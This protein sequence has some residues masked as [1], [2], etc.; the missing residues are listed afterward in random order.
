MK[1]FNLV[2]QFNGDRILAT[3]EA[4][5]RILKCCRNCG[6][7]GGHWGHNRCPNPMRCKFCGSTT[8]DSGKNWECP[9]WCRYAI[10]TFLFDDYYKKNLKTRN[11]FVSLPSNMNDNWIMNDWVF[12]PTIEELQ[13][14]KTFEHIKKIWRMTDIIKYNIQNNDIFG[15]DLNIEDLSNILCEEKSDENNLNSNLNQEIARNKLYYNNYNYNNN[16]QLDKYK[17]M[18]KQRMRKNKNKNK[19][20]NINNIESNMNIDNKTDSSEEDDNDIDDGGGGWSVSRNKGNRLSTQ[21]HRK[22]LRDYNRFEMSS[23]KNNNNNLSKNNSVINNGNNGKNG[24]HGINSK[25]KNKNGKSVDYVKI[26]EKLTN[27]NSQNKKIKNRRNRKRKRVEDERQKRQK[28]LNDDF[29]RAKKILNE[30]REKQRDGE[31]KNNYN[32]NNRHT[33]QKQKQQQQQTPIIVN[34]SPDPPVRTQ[35]Q[36]QQ[37]PKLPTVE[38]LGNINSMVNNLQANQYQH[39]NSINENREYDNN[40]YLKEN[41]SMGNMNGRNGGNNRH[42][43]PKRDHNQRTLDLGHPNSFVG[44]HQADM[45][46]AAGDI[47]NGH[48][49]PT[50]SYM[51]GDQRFTNHN[52]NNNTYSLNEARFNP[53]GNTNYYN[54][55]NNNNN[56]N[57]NN[58][59]GRLGRF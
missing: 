58:G 31:F 12:T 42:Y 52:Y 19:N 45:V 50:K 14:G 46:N 40:M 3:R 48:Y 39:I 30:N 22:L 9:Y 1:L 43:R 11:G 44:G 27:I 38:N 20:K 8:H 41:P 53:I 16:I 55:K 59:Y 36:Q 49:G 6:H 28:Q 29:N 47:S 57:N 5:R 15:R 23:V 51:N 26:K 25:N 35:I 24:K 17:Q 21:Q 4:K 18:I 54:N 13:D 33:P 32:S 7:S 34:P 10:I 56:N 2:E 37:L